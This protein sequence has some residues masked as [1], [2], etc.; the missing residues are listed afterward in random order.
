M[1]TP[2]VKS[3]TVLQHQPWTCRDWDHPWHQVEHECVC[4]ASM[5]LPFIASLQQ[6]LYWKRHHTHTRNLTQ[7][8]SLPQAHWCRRRLY[9]LVVHQLSSSRC[10]Q[11]QLSGQTQAAWGDAT[12]SPPHCQLFDVGLVCQGPY[13]TFLTYTAV[14]PTTRKHTLMG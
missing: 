7:G 2:H 11:V 5:F 12:V 6:H 4:E 8:S 3:D 14:L 13:T 9:K 10:V 1:N